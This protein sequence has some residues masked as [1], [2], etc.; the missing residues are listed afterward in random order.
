MLRRSCAL[1]RQVFI[2]SILSIFSILAIFACFSENFT[3]FAES[4]EQN[5]VKSLASMPILL[6]GGS[7]YRGKDGYWEV[8]ISEGPCILHQGDNEKFAD[9]AVIWAKKDRNR[10]VYD[11]R[12][13]FVTKI[14]KYTTEGKLL[15]D[16]LLE[17]KTET[18][19]WATKD[20]FEVRCPQAREIEYSQLGTQSKAKVPA[21]IEALYLAAVKHRIAPAVAAGFGNPMRSAEQPLTERN[22]Q[23]KERL[24]RRNPLYIKPNAG[25]IRVATYQQWEAS[26]V[27]QAQMEQGG[28][29][30]SPGT[31]P[32]DTR[33]VS[34]ES[35]TSAEVITTPA[36]T[37]TPGV[38]PNAL[39]QSA[40]LGKR[41]V[42]IFPM[43]QPL[44]VD[45]MPTGRQDEWMGILD[46]G[47]NVLVD[48]SAVVDGA[49]L[50]SV[51][52]TA[53]RVV[54]WMRS[55]STP[56]L[57]GASVQDNGTPL[58]IYSEGNI[59][60]R[61]GERVIRASKMFYNAQTSAGTCYDAE[62]LTPLEAVEGIAR[63]NADRVMRT[64]PTQFI[65]Q[66]GYITTSRLASPTYRLEASNIVFD[67]RRY[68]L[69][70]LI[71][72]EPIIDPATGKQRSVAD[73]KISSTN[74]VLYVGELPVFYWPWLRTD[75]ANPTYFIKD[76]NA[77][78]NSIF[79]V[80]AGVTWDASQL[81][82][83][84]SSLGDWD[85][86]LDWRS[87][88]GLGHGTS[89]NYNFGPN[90]IAIRNFG[91]A[92][93]WGIQDAGRDY[94]GSRRNDLPLEQDYRYLFD[95]Q[96]TAYLR[97]GHKLEA[98]LAVISDK[99]FLEQYYEKDWE[100]SRDK[101]TQLTY[102]G[103]DAN[104]SF[105]VT[106]SVRMNDFYTQTQWL[107][108]G[109]HFWLGQDLLPGLLTW[110]EHSSVGYADNRIAEPAAKTGEPWAPLPWEV[111]TRGLR[112]FTRH[113]IDAPFS[114]GAVRMVPFLLGEAGYWG[115]DL[116][117]DSLTRLYWAAG[118]R[119]SLPALAAFPNFRS[120]LF[121]THGLVYKSSLEMEFFYS[122]SDQNLG[123]MPIYDRLY[124]DSDEAFLN[125]ALGA[126]NRVWQNAL[127]L[128][129]RYDARLYALRSMTGGYV[130]S[131]VP[132]VAGGLS[133]FRVDW[134]NR[135]QTKR[136][137][138][139]GRVV[140]WITFDVGCNIFPDADRDN[141]GKTI[142]MADYDF[143]WNLGTR[144]SI[145][146]S[147]YFDFFEQGLNLQSIGFQLSRE[148]RGNIYCGFTRV[149]GPTENYFVNANYSYL[150]SKKWQSQASVSIDLEDNENV[151]VRLGFTRIGES[152]LTGLSMN[153][154]AATE[155]YGI[156][157]VIAPRINFG[158]RASGQTSSGMGLGFGGGSL[159]PASGKYGLE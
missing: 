47:V 85:V 41:R 64:S 145:L 79:G 138:G 30:A 132:E 119:A 50:P 28:D 98:D 158:S 21:A 155:D 139:S 150:M 109:D 26:R 20:T 53:D 103:I 72:G 87:M 14:K 74:N 136:N 88:R 121:N 84:D 58:E 129:G 7:F 105:S 146:S 137:Y 63:I 54:I 39:Q 68:P 91:S 40:P 13:F 82:N 36:G 15:D 16:H 60:L 117:G 122:E 45:W 71:S 69:T 44:S 77:G 66:N 90:G 43:G 94:L 25:K 37:P 62:I 134:R 106:G 147:G 24:S 157:L 18:F 128:D 81:F 78:Y 149:E 142:G 67:D 89:Y 115:E 120:N 101:V 135:W 35:V 1:N 140:D 56:S 31:I 95:W 80:Q 156:G 114:L 11:I 12:A 104:R 32:I 5:N 96:H 4:S 144:T 111:E 99:N 51:D 57:S 27:R 93:Y 34:P 9:K 76:V 141:F 52:M 126:P 19:Y 75:M 29:I 131:L 55:K 6:E 110:Y 153:Y 143:A 23:E 92:D 22:E 17:T 65:V 100:Q 107:P 59:V 46:G 123:N 2:F 38:L 61:E 10:G 116:N 42:R 159:A 124:D 125:Y 133:T 83:L 48:N 108:R 113:E 118:V 112:A 73:Q 8:W 148:E 33:L 97:N 49:A 152:L 102:S 154:N 3:I 70:H 151:G 86:S 127:P 130:S